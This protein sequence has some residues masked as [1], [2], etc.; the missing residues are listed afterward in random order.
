MSEQSEQPGQASDTV[1]LAEKKVLANHCTGVVKWFNVRNGY[2]FI[3]RDDNKEDVFIHQTAIIK[4]NPRKYLRSV[5]DGEKVEFDVVEGEKGL[6][7]AANVTGPDGEPVKGSKYAADRRRF[8]PRF[9]PRPKDRIPEANEDDEQEGEETERP[10]R[11]TRPRRYYRRPP[12]W[13]RQGPR[14]PPQN[15][16]GETEGDEHDGG[17]KASRPRRLRP[18]RPRRQ[19]EGEEGQENGI[20]REEQGDEASDRPPR[21]RRPRYRRRGPPRDKQNAES[22]GATGAVENRTE[23][24]D[25]PPRRRRPRPNRPRGPRPARNEGEQ[26]IEGQMVKVNGTAE[27]ENEKQ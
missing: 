27:N 5:G 15:E 22:D 11:Q 18:R 1:V 16:E 3:N 8:R 20:D 7:E 23:E 19:P 13:F 21:R 14:R 24:G 9:R 6:P 26:D 17:E 25:K 12:P 4:N 2:G 10:V